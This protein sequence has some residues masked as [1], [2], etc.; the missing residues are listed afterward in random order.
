M[1]GVGN[2]RARGGGESLVDEVVGQEVD[3]GLG[4]PV[5]LVGR[6]GQ[7]GATAVA[8]SG[9]GVDVLVLHDPRLQVGVDLDVVA[10][11]HDGVAAGIRRVE[12]DD[13]EVARVGLLVRVQGRRFI[14]IDRGDRAVGSFRRVG[15]VRD[16]VE[17]EVVEAVRDRVGVAVKGP[18][19][20]LGRVLDRDGGDLLTE[21]QDLRDRDDVLHAVAA[22]AG[23]LR[24]GGA[25]SEQDRA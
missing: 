21:G 14:G 25:R 22:M 10:R 12:L 18:R 20:H 19:V 6:R 1:V 9:L 16:G 5:R 13:D 7:P 11:R 15:N 2:Q 24:G 23:R 17:P 4:W 3:R 8:F